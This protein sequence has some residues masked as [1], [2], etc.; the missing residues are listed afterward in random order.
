M[1]DYLCEP[2]TYREIM[3]VWGPLTGKKKRFQDYE[4]E[5]LER[6]FEI[7]RTAVAD[8]QP[9][10][11]LDDSLEIRLA[12]DASNTGTGAYLYQIDNEGN[13]RNVAMSAQTFSTPAS[14]A[15]RECQEW[16]TKTKDCMPFTKP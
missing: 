14:P 2:S 11:T 13:V 7:A 6:V 1:S 12:V 16:D 9:L 10:Y 15:R 3:R 8:I 4:P 5:E